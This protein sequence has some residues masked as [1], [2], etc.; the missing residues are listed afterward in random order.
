M[1]RWRCWNLSKWLLIYQNTS[2]QAT[3]RKN[4]LLAYIEF[5]ISRFSLTAKH[6]LR[7]NCLTNIFKT[8]MASQIDATNLIVRSLWPS[9]YIYLY[10]LGKLY[11]NYCRWGADAKHV[12]ASWRHCEFFF[13][14]IYVCGL[15]FSYQE[16]HKSA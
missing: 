16:R 3:R 2:H 13:I 1:T 9:L 12:L 10:F 6:F 15:F 11:S 14:W 8:K 5:E 4:E 7:L